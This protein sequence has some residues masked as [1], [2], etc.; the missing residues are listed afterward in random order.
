LVEGGDMNREKQE[1]E[2]LHHRSENTL[3]RHAGSVGEFVKRGRTTDLAP[4]SAF[5][6]LRWTL[7]LGL[8]TETKDIASA[9]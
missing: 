8:L 6:A 3:F 1:R 4:I 2:L 7:I 9:G 5:W